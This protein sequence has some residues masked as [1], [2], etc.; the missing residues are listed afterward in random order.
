MLSSAQV[1]QTFGENLPWTPEPEE[2][3]IAESRAVPAPPSAVPVIPLEG[4]SSL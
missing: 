2:G 4:D 1:G 3:N